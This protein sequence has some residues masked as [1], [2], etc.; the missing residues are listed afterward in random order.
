VR[1][2]AHLRTH[3]VM[4]IDFLETTAPPCVYQTEYLT[5]GVL[6]S[7]PSGGKLLN[8]TGLQV[9]YQYMTFLVVAWERGE[10]NIYVAT[11]I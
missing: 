9:Q 10:V 6:H 1:S 8:H 5:H 7:R 3:R 11:H 2:T 4:G